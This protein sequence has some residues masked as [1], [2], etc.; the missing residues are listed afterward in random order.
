MKFVIVNDRAARAAQCA[1]CAK[2][3]SAGYLH[4]IQSRRF[5]CDHQCYTAHGTRLA[6]IGSR[7]ASGIDQ[8]PIGGFKDPYSF[9][10]G[11]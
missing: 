11:S 2:L 6:P 10:F 4:E 8:L 3:I 1:H 7:A 5:Y 9:V